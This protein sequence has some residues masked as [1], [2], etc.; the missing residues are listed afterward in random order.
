M[1][2]VNYEGEKEKEQQTFQWLRLVEKDHA[3]GQCG[4]RRRDHVDLEEVAAGAID[5][6]AA[7][8]LHTPANEQP[9]DHAF[10][11]GAAD[12][13]RSVA[14]VSESIS[15]VAGR[16]GLRGSRTR[17]SSRLDSVL[18]ARAVLRHG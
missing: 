1:C 16:H 13:S 14:D 10:Y 11:A 2:Y 9:V 12:T 6:H 5:P 17:Q 3:K 18:P 15:D 7:A 4:R 8:G